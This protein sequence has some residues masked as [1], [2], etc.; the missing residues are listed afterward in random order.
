VDA[1]RTSHNENNKKN[2]TTNNACAF[3][4]VKLLSTR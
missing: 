4:S 3:Y 2:N 1:K